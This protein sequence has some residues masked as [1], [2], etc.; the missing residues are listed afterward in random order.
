MVPNVPSDGETPTAFFAALLA[1]VLNAGVDIPARAMVMD[2]TVVP[3]LQHILPRVLENVLTS[4]SFWHSA[5]VDNVC[6]SMYSAERLIIIQILMCVCAE[7]P[8]EVSRDEHLLAFMNRVISEKTSE[9]QPDESIFR[10]CAALLGV[11]GWVA[12]PDGMILPC[13]C[14]TCVLKMWMCAYDRLPA[15][16]LKGPITQ[17]V[18]GRDAKGNELTRTVSQTCRAMVVESSG[19]QKPLLLALRRAAYL[20]LISAVAKTQSQE[21]IYMGLLFKEEFM[22]GEHLWD[23]LV[24][25]GAAVSFPVRC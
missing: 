25:R 16:V 3:F 10:R 19:M 17:A 2:E 7:P 5:Q 23:N 9:T 15:E 12:S 8:Q 14:S 22:R 18:F 20:T 21:K 24:D 1:V 4:A 11:G 13:G 6:N